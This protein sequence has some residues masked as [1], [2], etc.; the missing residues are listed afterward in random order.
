MDTFLNIHAGNVHGDERM[1]SWEIGET[2]LWKNR[3]TPAG[4]EE[5]EYVTKEHASNWNFSVLVVFAAWCVAL[6]RKRERVNY[7]KR[8][9]EVVVSIEMVDKFILDEG[10]GIRHEDEHGNESDENKE[11]LKKTLYKL[12]GARFY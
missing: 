5:Y 3:K 4:K 9:D 7:E 6:V 11:L 10:R 12:V 8:S 2:E 1:V